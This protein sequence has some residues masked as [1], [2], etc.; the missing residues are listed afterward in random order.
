MQDEIKQPSKRGGA[1]KGA[2]RKAAENPRNVRVSFSL[3]AK[4]AENLQ[5][6]ADAAGVSRNDWIIRVLESYGDS[7]GGAS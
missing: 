3:T 4:A 6:A 2:G 5:K 1:R 7:D